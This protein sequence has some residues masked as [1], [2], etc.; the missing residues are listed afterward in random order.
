MIVLPLDLCV[1][2]TAAAARDCRAV[3]N[4]LVPTLSLA[5]LTVILH[6]A[7]TIAMRVTTNAARRHFFS[8]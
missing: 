7:H 2:A 6:L 3:L 8:R 4:H 5:F 1:R